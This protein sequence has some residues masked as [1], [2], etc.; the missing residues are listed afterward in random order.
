MARRKK[1]CGAYIEFYAK[2]EWTRLDCKRGPT[3]CKSEHSTPLSVD[4][5]GKHW[6]DWED[7][8]GGY[9][10]YSFGVIDKA[11]KVPDFLQLAT[12]IRYVSRDG[13]MR[14]GVMTP[15]TIP[16]ADG[17]VIDQDLHTFCKENGIDA[18]FL[19]W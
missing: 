17:T 2:G 14:S 16:D 12:E 9:K 8:G 1:Y 13:S 5:A 6:I 19:G 3:H 18:G 10:R 7:A 4:G 15:E 11:Y